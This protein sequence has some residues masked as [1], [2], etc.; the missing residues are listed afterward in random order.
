MTKTLTENGTKHG[1]TTL[2]VDLG[3]VDGTMLPLVGGKAANLGEL[4]RAGLPAPPGFCVTTEAYAEI[5]SSTS[6]DFQNPDCGPRMRE[7]LSSARCPAHI[8]AAVVEA[9][10]RLGEGTPVAVR[11]S[12]T[13]EDL[14]H[15]SFAG[16]Q[17]TY[18]N[19]IGSTAVLEAVRRC[20]ASLWTD[21][22]V[23]YRATNGIEHRAVRLAVVV[24]RMVD[25]ATAGVLFTANP[26]NGH[27]R[28]AVIDA[29]PGLGEAVVSGAVNPDHFEVDRDSG[30]ILERRLGDKRFEVVALAG[31]GTVRAER[32]D[33]GATAC[34]T[35]SQIRALAA[36]G[37]RVERHFGA[38]QDTEWAI[39]PSGDLWLA[40]ARPITTLFPLPAGAGGAG[41]RAYF[42]FSLAQGL[43]RPITPMGLA[44]F[45]VLASS[46]ARIMSIRV[47]D[48]LCGPPVFAEAG[49]RVFVDVTSTLKGPVGRLLLPRVLD[50]M[51]A[52]SGA[53]LRA[54]ADDA[55][56]SCGRRSRWPFVRRALRIAARYSAPMTVVQAL[57]SPGAA[58]AR[59]ERI[60]T[61]LEQRLTP[62]PNATP[63]ERLS[64]IVR[65]LETEAVPLAPKLTPAAAAAFAMLG[66]AGKLLGLNLTDGALQTV[67]R[68][69]PNNVTT[70]MDL[71]LWKVACA[72]RQDA[73][74]ARLVVDLPAAELARRHQNSALPEAAQS[75]V[76][77]FLARYGHRGVAEIDIGVPRW[78]EDPAHI[79]G[80]LA[81]YLRVEKPE[82]APDAVFARGAGEAEAMVETLVSR[83]RRRGRLRAWAVR[84]ALRRARELAGIRELPKYYLV[85]VLAALRREL[86]A[87]GAALAEQEKIDTAE[88]VFFLNF[89]DI[90]AGIEG[91]DLQALV[92][93]RREEYEQEFRRRHIPGVLLSDGTEP[94]AKS[95]AVAD[96]GALTGT[97]ASPGTVTGVAR[98][99]LEPAGAHLEP[100]EIL[101]A[102]STDP[103]WTPLFLTA[104][105]LVM[106]MGGANTHGAVVARE[107]GIPAVV[108]V[109]DAAIRIADGQRIRVDGSSGTITILP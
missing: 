106:E 80:V 41:T 56:F 37:D 109:R 103:G 104:G 105:G 79:F 21:R 39:D 88:D 94:E 23:F 99:I 59:A 24:Q 6:C 63:S 7:A 27:R 52:R 101:V 69:V 89:N 68:G 32:P 15:A 72:I 51:E 47:D 2:V 92:T 3:D 5:A 14:P 35:D 19:V 43:H 102:P 83:A 61:E 107:Y 45:R 18:L 36:L 4:I 62:P 48:P 76:A 66:L 29:S 55:R 40:Q 98:V 1:K 53:T 22:A 20:W 108:G 25:V 75:A 50:M 54:L 11:S 96:S 30:E 42:C 65:A 57:A 13:A 34:I 10:R 90:R 74:A 82:M 16:Q 91:V 8:A 93:S 26:V 87:I 58:L 33:S 95:G 38:P 100:G 49:Q 31:G 71:D 78:S 12:A 70:E 85:C 86:K 17:D 67:M 97:P 9:Y 44:A 60:G 64:F 81:N 77:A 73:A 84:F 28:H 46:A